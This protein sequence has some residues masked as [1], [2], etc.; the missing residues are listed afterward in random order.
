MRTNYVFIDYENV[1]PANLSILQQEKFRV[2]VFVGENQ[3]KFTREV[4]LAMQ[5]MGSNAEYIEIAGNGRNALDF[6][7][8]YYIGLVSATDP[9]AF[10]HIVSKDAG[11]DPLLK[12]LKE[13]KIFADR[14]TDINDI[15][16]IKTSLAKTPNEKL[17]LIGARLTAP[18]ATKPKTTATL[19]SHINAMFGKQLEAEEI[20]ALVEGLKSTGIISVDGKK[21]AYSA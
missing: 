3:T 14:V 21:I 2:M 5:S 13:K 8:A 16:L 19:S 15:S 17:K 9:T 10:F 6:H 7:I 11:Y 4:V 1:Q 20:A 12:H 18:K